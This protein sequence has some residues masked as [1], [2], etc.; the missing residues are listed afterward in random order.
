M[1]QYLDSWRTWLVDLGTYRC[2]QL[3]HIQ[4]WLAFFELKL[5]G[6]LQVRNHLQLPFLLFLFPLSP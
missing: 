3:F 1:L 6:Y 5:R 4:S 2:Q